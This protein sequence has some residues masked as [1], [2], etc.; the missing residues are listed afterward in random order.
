MSRSPLH[1]ELNKSSPFANA[2]EEAY[3]N[4]VRTNAALSGRVRALFKTKGLSESS[5]NVLRILRGSGERG[6]PSQ[7]IAPD[8]V[9]AVPDVTRLVDRLERS[10]LAER[11]RCEDDRRMVYVRITAKGR[12]V[13]AELDGPLAALHA[14]LLGHM[15]EADVGRLSELLAVARRAHEHHTD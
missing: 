13:L 2:Q 3:L 12:S 5:Y 1:R 15:P 14:E 4:L 7:K 9:V 10:G 6:R 11:V 8:M